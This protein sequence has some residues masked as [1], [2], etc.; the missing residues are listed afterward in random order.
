MCLILERPEDPGKGKTWREHPP[1]RKGEEE[2]D[3][4]LW[5][6]GL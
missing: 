1:R 5:E 4:K 3:E 2:W 6:A